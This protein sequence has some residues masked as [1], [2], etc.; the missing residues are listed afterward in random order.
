[1]FVNRTKELSQLEMRYHENKAEFVVVYGRRRVG[2]TVL[3]KQFTQE[4]EHVYF[5]ADLRPEAEQLRYFTQQLYQITQ[6]PM[7]ALESFSSWDSALT[8]L[9][10]VCQDRRLI[11]VIDEYPYLC[12]V[13]PAFP[14]ILQRIWDERLKISRIF[15]VLCG[16][17]ISM[18]EREV[19]GRTSPLYGRRTSQLLVQPMDFFDAQQFFPDR[20]I[21]EQIETYAIAGGIPAYLEQFEPKRKLWGDV[22]DIVLRKDGF[23]YDEVSFLLMEE[24]REPRNYFAI[25]SAIASGK[26]RLNEIAQEA[27]LPGPTVGRYLD[28]LRDLRILRRVLPVTENLPHKSKKGLYKIIDPF[29]R[30][31]FRFVY[32]NRGFLEEEDIDFVLLNKIKPHFTDFVAQVFEEVSAQLLS[33]LNSANRLPF[34]AARIGAWW[35][36]T[37]EIDVVALSD[38]S[39][40]QA[41]HLSAVLVAECKWT[42]KPVGTNILDDLKTKAQI[43]TKEIPVG[44]IHYAL[45]SRSGFTE[46]LQSIADA[47]GIFL[48][49]LDDFK[50]IK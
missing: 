44:Q 3:L 20:D 7:L 21:R 31:W 43:L 38:D 29:F 49:T 18:M 12:S 26:T 33:K 39:A 47:E 30:F 8:Y 28:I 11:V 27:S 4:K 17:S 5:L 2:K 36:R 46:A 13:N 16:S 50:K 40:Q 45:F 14:S 34:K 42:Q 41:P 25:L 10:Q 24:L 19:L 32:P 23:L 1:M 35:S 6:E 22:R 48:F 15:L 37:E 9:V